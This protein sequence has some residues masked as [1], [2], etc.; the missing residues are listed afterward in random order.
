MSAVS[1]AHARSDLHAPQPT[2]PKTL[3]Q[4]NRQRPLPSRSLRDLRSVLRQTHT[5]RTPACVLWF[6]SPSPATP[7]PHTPTNHNPQQLGLAASD[8][9]CRAD[10]DMVHVHSLSWGVRVRASPNE[11]AVEVLVAASGGATSEWRRAMHVLTASDC[12]VSVVSVS[13]N[14]RLMSP[15]NA[16]MRKRGFS[17]RGEMMC[18]GCSRVGGCGMSLMN[19]AR[20][21]SLPDGVKLGVRCGETARPGETP[22]ASKLQTSVWSSS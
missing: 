16:L 10:C 2:E 8:E 19:A 18:A 9:S 14:A 20:R 4:H 21:A 17:G 5:P 7:A 1:N 15:G 3:P 11:A 6:C 12:G 22:P 13:K